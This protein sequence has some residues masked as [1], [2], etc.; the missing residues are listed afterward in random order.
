MEDAQPVDWQAVA[1]GFVGGLALFLFG[2][3]ELSRALKELAGER[4]KHVLERASAHPVR[5]LATG[6]LA[7]FALDSSSATIILLIAIIDA[8]LIAA[9]P[10]LPIILGSNIGTTLSSQ[11]FAAGLDDYAPII[12]AAG[13]L[14]RTFLENERAKTWASVVF[15]LGLVLYALFLIG[16]AAAPLE[17][18]PRVKGWLASAET[19]LVGVAIGAA[20]TIALQSSSAVLGLVI[21]LAGGGLVTLPAGIAMMLGAEIGTCA[22]TLVATLGRSR[23][24]IRAGLFHLGF[25]IVTAAI[26]LALIGPLTALAQASAGSVQQQIANAHVAFNVLGALLF[27][28][29]LPLA[30]RLL[31]KLAPDAPEPAA[32]QV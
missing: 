29:L 15:A 3:S 31:A 17:G 20:V 24:A 12:V 1:L 18:D 6:A 16:E 25:N 27:L 23:Q 28:P 8:G 22:D 9:G 14:A 11:I 7:T 5:G 32:K 19:P 26:G 30:A 10:A 21:T 2:V 13:L 4:L